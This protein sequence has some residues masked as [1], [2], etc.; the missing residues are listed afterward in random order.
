MARDTGAEAAGVGAAVE[1][2]P[3]AAVGAGVAGDAGAEA[4]GVGAAVGTATGAAAGAAM[5][6][7]AGAGVAVDDG[8]EATGLPGLGLI[9]V[10]ERAVGEEKDTDTVARDTPPA[11]AP[12]AAPDPLSVVPDQGADLLGYI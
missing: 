7:T 4:A 3:G 10:L 9:Q 8:A 11:P 2:A 1:A 6:A 5:G 12:V